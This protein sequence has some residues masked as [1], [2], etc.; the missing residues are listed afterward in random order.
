MTA[1]EE[2]YAQIKKELL[3]IVFGVRKYETYLYGRH[4]NMESGHK[5]LETIFKKSLLSA[6]KR[7]QAMLLAEVPTTTKKS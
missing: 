1:V 7:L 2:N 5:P 4:S 6:P 3:A